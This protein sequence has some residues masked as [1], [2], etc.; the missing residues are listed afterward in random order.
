MGVV[1]RSRKVDIVSRMLGTRK[2]RLTA[3][4]PGS[5]IWVSS[6]HRRINRQMTEKGLK[7]LMKRDEVWGRLMTR[8]DAARQRVPEVLFA[9][10]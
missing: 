1:N 10:R 5:S 7:L 8:K 3:V 2:V 9:V 4:F 6:V